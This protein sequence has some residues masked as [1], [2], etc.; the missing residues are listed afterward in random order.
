MKSSPAHCLLNT[1]FAG[2]PFAGT[3]FAGT[4]FA[5]TPF[6]GTPFA[7]TPFAGTPLAASGNSALARFY[8]VACGTIASIR[9]SPAA[10][11]SAMAP[12]YDDPVMPTR[13]SPGPSSLTRGCRASQLTRCPTSFTS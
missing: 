4:P 12:P 11:S 7:G 9:W 6:A 10:A 13:G 2:T 1:P 8:H 3:P 5:G